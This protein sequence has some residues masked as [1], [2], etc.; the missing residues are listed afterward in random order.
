MKK[1]NSKSNIGETLATVAAIVGIGILTAASE[2]YGV[3]TTT[4][5]TARTI[6]IEE[7]ETMYKDGPYKSAKRLYNS[8]MEI[9]AHY[10]T[11]GRTL[12][13]GIISVRGNT[14]TIQSYTGT[15]VYNY[16]SNGLINDIRTSV[17]NVIIFK[18]DFND[19]LTGI[20]YSNGKS[21]VFQYDSYGRLVKESEGLFYRRYTYN[22][23]NQ[24]TNVSDSDGNYTVYEYDYEG[25]LKNI[26]KV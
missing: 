22:Y 19:R 13:G 10:K 20:T 4:S 1:N 2:T 7:L 14:I 6:S 11:N 12:D 25:N 16:R 15:V 26:K 17:D 8:A 23:H 3:S 5:S 21:S 24:I 9:K 18:Y